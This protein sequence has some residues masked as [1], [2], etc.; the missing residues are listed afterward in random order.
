MAFALGRTIPIKFQLADY[1]GV[2]ITSLSAV[3]SLQVAPVSSN[4]SLGTPSNAAPAGGTALRYDPTA[5]QFV[6]NWQ[7]KGLAAGSYAIL[8][9]LADGTQRTK[10]IQLTAAGSSAGMLSDTAGGSTAATAGAL[11]GGNLTLSINDPNSLFTADERARIAQAIASVDATIAPYGVT[12]TQVSDGD[13]T[14][15]VTLDTGS[16]SAVGG[17]ANGVLG[18]ETDSGEITLIQGWNWY[19][20]SDPTAVG[21]GQY[22]FETVVIHEL[23]HAL[24]LGHSANSASV[25]YATLA[26]GTA[27]RAMTTADLNVPD[28]DGGGGCGLHTAGFR[29]ATPPVVNPVAPGSSSAAVGPFTMTPLDNAIAGR[30]ALLTG[31]SVLSAGARKWVLVQRDTLGG[32][33]TS[34][35][36]LPVSAVSR[37]PVLDPG[38]VDA[39]LSDATTP[40]SLLDL[41]WSGHPAGKRKPAWRS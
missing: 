40:Q 17:Y 27:N 22:D 34:G 38:L 26:A 20:G 23:G 1:N 32:S 28:S 18:C 35:M 9:N 13:A 31:W 19:A 21:S 7:T 6:F 12:I 2:S 10:T 33:R 41:T 37:K 3:T 16:T 8:L 5:N 29:Q 36:I 30:D 24:G 11:L 4:G 25:M 15:S 39:L 14:A